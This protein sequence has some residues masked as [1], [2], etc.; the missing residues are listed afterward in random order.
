MKNIKLQYLPWLTLI[1]GI[2]GLALQL[3]LH[4]TGVDEEGLLISGHFAGIVLFVLTALVLAGLFLALRQLHPVSR[5]S[6][7]FP[8]STS[9]FVGCILAAAGIII[10]SVS[11]YLQLRDKFALIG[12]ILA[13]AA[14]ISLVFVGLCRKQGRQPNFLFH[15]VLTLYTM[16]QLVFLYRHWSPEPQLLLYFFPLLGGVFLMLTAYQATCLDGGKGNRQWYAFC[17]LAAV[18]FCCVSLAGDYWLFYLSMGIWAFTNL[19]SLQAGKSRPA[20]TKEA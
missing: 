7:L 11:S 19:C 18:F 17:S 6:K 14:G 9:A 13:I 15:C 1:A 2:L 3:L 5:Y 10:S 12:A 16:L 20:D 8:A 4:L